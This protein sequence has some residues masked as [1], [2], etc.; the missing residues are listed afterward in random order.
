MTATYQERPDRAGQ[1]ACHEDSQVQ[2][3]HNGSPP[4]VASTRARSVVLAAPTVRAPTLEEDARP[5]DD[6]GGRRSLPGISRQAHPDRRNRPDPRSVLIGDPAHRHPRSLHPR[7]AIAQLVEG[8]LRQLRLPG[9]ATGAVRAGGQY[10]GPPALT[11]HLELGVP[12]GVADR[13]G[14]LQLEEPVRHRLPGQRA[15]RR[16]AVVR[17]EPQSLRREFCVEPVP[18]LAAG[19][20]RARSR[21]VDRLPGQTFAERVNGCVEHAGAGVLRRQWHE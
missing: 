8:D 12:A 10:I 13:G 6:I 4:T 14:Q 15:V 11:G 5:V 20:G 21:S 19:Q 3:G 2:R 18:A 16:V 9:H 17:E 7:G 1:H